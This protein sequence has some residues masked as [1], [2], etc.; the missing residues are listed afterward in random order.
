M[1]TVTGMEVQK[2]NKKRVNVYLDGDYAFSL[3]LDDAARLRKGQVLTDGEVD[4][5]RRI[6][7]VSRAM[8]TAAHFLSYRPR[9]VQEVRRKLEEHDISADVVELALEKLDAMGYLDDHAFAAFWVNERSNSKPLS[10]K[11]LKYELRQKGIE[12]PIIAEV[13]GESA[14][15]DEMAYR[16]AHNRAL[17]L[18]GS[19]RIDFRTK[20]SGL[21][22]RRG[23]SY[24][25]IKS[26]LRQLEAELEADDPN[27]F[28]STGEDGADMD[29]VN[30]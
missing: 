24:S 4:T 11:A 15:E 5:L 26:T 8:D 12:D 13:V 30:D 28:S 25:V 29:E 22:Q 18:R 7:A 14:P 27:F 21:L 16:A 19:T 6:D 2:R 9:S 17:R 23:F 1:A 10:P 20:I 3:S